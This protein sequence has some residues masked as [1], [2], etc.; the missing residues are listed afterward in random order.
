M[1]LKN[2]ANCL[3]RNLEVY[4]IIY[5]SSV[6]HYVVGLNLPPHDEHTPVF[7]KTYTHAD[8]LMG[9]CTEMSKIN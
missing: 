5:L 8:I 4:N 6:N 2:I 9:R 1:F 7:R 3:I